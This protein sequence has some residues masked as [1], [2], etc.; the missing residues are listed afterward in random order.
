MGLDEAKYHENSLAGGNVTYIKQMSKKQK[1][2]CL[3]LVGCEGQSI[4]F[5]FD[6]LEE[7]GTAL[8]DLIIGDYR[9]V[10]RSLRLAIELLVFWADF[11]GDGRTGVDAY[12]DY[13]R[14]KLTKEDFYYLFNQLLTIRHIRVKERLIIKEKQRRERPFQ[15]MTSDLSIVSGKE[16]EYLFSK[17]QT[18]KIGIESTF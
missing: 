12:G 3:E 6:I 4:G 11:E 1:E 15:S 17:E 2:Y 5:M 14:E 13:S 10:S 16:G 8:R 18:K 9:G 7:L